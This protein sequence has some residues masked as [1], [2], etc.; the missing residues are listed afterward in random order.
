MKIKLSPV[1]SGIPILFIIFSGCGKK[2]VGNDEIQQGS[3][4]ITVTVQH[5]SGRLL[6][7]FEISTQ[8]ATMRIFSD[9]TGYAALVNIPKG[10]YEV[11]VKKADFPVFSKAATVD[12]GE[13]QKI[14][15]TYIPTVNVS[16]YDDTG[17]S[18]PGAKILTKPPT[19]EFVTNQNGIAICNNMPQ[20][21]LQFTIKRANYA[22]TILEVPSLKPTVDLVVASASPIITIISPIHDTVIPSPSNVK[23]TGGGYDLEDGVLPDSS[24]AW[25]SDRDGRLGSGQTLIVPYLSPGSHKIT[26]QGTD[27]DKKTSQT[28]IPVTVKDFQLNSYFPIPSG[29]TW[30]Y[31]YMIPEFYIANQDK[32]SEFWSLQNISVRIDGFQRITELYWDVTVQQVVTHRRL[33]LTDY[34]EVENGNIYIIKTT[35]NTK[36]WKG[37]MPPY[38]TM[39]VT[40]SYTPRYLFLKNTTDVQAEKH[41]ESTVQSETIW[42]YIYYSE[43]SE[44]YHEINILTTSIQVE[45]EKSIQT[46]KGIFSA[47]NLTITQK[48]AVKKWSLT[49]G[50]GLVR[51]EDNAFNPSAVA[52]LRDASIYRFYT[53]PAQKTVIEPALNPIPP[54][55]LNFEIDRTSFESMRAFEK[56]LV[57]FCPR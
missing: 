32:N 48:N 50:I 42:S 45:D 12:I 1:L 23:L 11:S 47:V 51:T 6:P 19:F 5:D 43:V 37:I 31:R 34:L 14:L 27:S 33:T 30:S 55:H 4:G 39:D 17:R 3:S 53:L 26:L 13:I 20:T 41:Y 57:G 22:D 7:G 52:V 40:T 46:D 2:T 54:Q 8:P 21:P 56:F 28:T 9:S 24:L 44:N 15:F 29:E 35:E 10:T 18:C 16:I 49:K 25:F 36:E 38:L